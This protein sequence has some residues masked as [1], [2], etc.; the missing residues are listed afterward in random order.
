MGLEQSTWISLF[1][2]GMMT[3]ALTLLFKVGKKADNQLFFRTESFEKTREYC[4][5]LGIDGTATIGDVKKA[6]KVKS[7]ALHPSN[8]ETGDKKKFEELKLAYETLA[9]GASLGTPRS[10]ISKKL[11]NRNKE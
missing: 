4:E 2:L 5:L 7:K 10:E 3:V 9:Y 1:L 8:K 6:F 11:H